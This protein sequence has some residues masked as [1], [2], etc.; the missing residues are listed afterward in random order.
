MLE[1]LRTALSGTAVV[2]ITGTLSPVV[3][4]LTLVNEEAPDPVIHFW[5]RSVLKA[6]GVN[7]QCAG[8]E[9]LPSGNFVLVV[10]HQSHFDTLVLFT[11]IRRHLRFVAK[12]ELSKIP[13]FGAAL[14]RAGNVFVDRSS[15]GKDRATLDAAL[16][17]VRNRVSIVFFAEGT[18]SDDGVLRAF[19]KGAAIFAIEAQVPLVPAAVAGTHEIL[20]KGTLAI[21][22]RPA[23]LV[24]GQPIETRG[25]TVDA[26]DQ[27]TDQA[28]KAVSECLSQAN[29]MLGG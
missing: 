21:R 11:H 8:L 9:N 24:I 20:P 17:A 13:V 6:S 19:K 12:Q 16:D 25:L 10:N 23:A 5:A 14:K 18:R 22:P 3:S 28:H 2:G 1:L 27:L 26:R 29:S 7:T 15:S 4:L